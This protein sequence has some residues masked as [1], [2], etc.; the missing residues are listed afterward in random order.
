MNVLLID[1]DKYLLEMLRVSLGKVGHAMTEALDGRE[2]WNCF[3]SSPH[4]F[5]VIVTDLKMPVLDGMKL[6]KRLRAKGYD[7]PVII[8]TGHEDIQ[9]SIEALRLGA[10]D[11]LTKPFCARELIDILEKLSTVL[12]NQQRPLL[13]LPFF[14]ED[15]RI[16]IHSQTH[17]IPSAVA[18]LQDRVKLFCKMHRIDIRKIG[19]CLHEAMVNAVIHGNLEI[20]SSIKE[21]SPRKFEELLR[22]RELAPGYGE[23]QVDVRCEVT[24]E[25][26]IFEICDEGE[27]FDPKSLQFSD[28]TLM[29]PSGR[30]ILI[31][32]A[33]MDSVFWNEVG[34]RIT[35]IKKLSSPADA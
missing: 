23:R 5:D 20:S 34:N 10:F 2:G 4:Y 35:M 30:G 8:I 24:A 9:S 16:S 6:L 32:T 13:E 1:D 7:I 25:Q 26:F 3:I 19:L 11:L 21:D 14:T 22:Q 31:I 15:I 27:G 29:I 12:R 18:F 28:S 17:L 33:F